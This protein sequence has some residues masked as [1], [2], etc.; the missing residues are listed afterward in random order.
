MPAP[1]NGQTSQALADSRSLSPAP[2]PPPVNPDEDR[3]QGALLAAPPAPPKS[4]VLPHPLMLLVANLDGSPLPE[5][6]EWADEGLLDLEPDSLVPL[7]FP[8]AWDD[9]ELSPEERRVLFVDQLSAVYQTFRPSGSRPA[10]PS[11]ATASPTP[12]SSK[13]Q[14][15]LKSLLQLRDAVRPEQGRPSD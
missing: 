9:R 14:A 12:P 6:Q 5:F 13:P 7:W 8:W 4:L 1:S 3:A 11:G 15:V 2:P 10:T